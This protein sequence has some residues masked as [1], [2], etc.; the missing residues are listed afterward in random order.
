MAQGRRGLDSSFF[1][2]VCSLTLLHRS[3]I[4]ITL[5]F[6]DSYIVLNIDPRRRSKTRNTKRTDHE[7][8]TDFASESEHSDS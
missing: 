6:H 3:H 5:L 7:S 1:L 8:S 2:N 4:T